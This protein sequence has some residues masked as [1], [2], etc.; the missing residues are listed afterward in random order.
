MRIGV[1]NC[2]TPFATAGSGSARWCVASRNG[3]RYFLKQFLTPIRPSLSSGVP[4]ALQE[5]QMERCVAFERRKRAL[6]EALGCVLGD[7][8]VPVSDF[9]A[10]EGRYFAASEYVLAP[11]KT[12]ETVDALSP[13]IAREL[14]FELARCLGR[15]HAQGIVHADLKPEHVLLQREGD[16]YR[17]RLIDFDSG[18]LEN[19]PPL[20]PRNI[21]GDPIYLSPEAFLCMTGEQRP[22][23]RKLDTFAFGAIAHRLWT[24]KLPETGSKKVHYL[25]E[26]ALSGGIIRLSDDLPAAYR[27]LIRK[28]LSRDPAE[29]PDDALLER[30]FAPPESE[31]RP[32]GQAVNGLSRFM[33]SEDKQP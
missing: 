6:Y 5:K 13:R 29:R 19:D 27:W 2:V 24:G 28:T 1:Y 33:R 7:C 14:L 30:L 21:E 32:S 25:Y 22:L 16:S 10:F 12:F 9:F 11:R 20:E 8:V 17:V 31:T 4:P 18:F 23:T 15:L 3:G 26:A